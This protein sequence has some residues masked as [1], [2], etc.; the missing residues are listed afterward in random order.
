MISTF[1]HEI[2]E[3]TSKCDKDQLGNL[4]SLVKTCWDVAYVN[5]IE[6]KL[7]FVPDR[8]ARCNYLDFKV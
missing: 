7:A 3:E 8:E 4:K 5:F 2:K 6:E 1:S